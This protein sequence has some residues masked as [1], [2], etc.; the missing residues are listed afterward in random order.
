MRAVFCRVP[1]HSTI[2]ELP[3]PFG[4]VGEPSTTGDSEGGEAAVLNVPVGWLGEGVNVSDEMGFEKFDR[5]FTVIQLLFVVRFL[6]SHVLLEA[7]GAGLGGDDQPVD[8]GSVGVGGEV[9]A[10][11][12]AAD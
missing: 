9:V 12:C 11:D 3:D 2:V 8:N 4:R 6:G 1:C 7:V 10:C 5:L